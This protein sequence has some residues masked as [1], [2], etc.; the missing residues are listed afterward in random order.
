MPPQGPVPEY[1]VQDEGKPVAAVARELGLV[2]SAVSTW[3][4]HARADQTQK[5]TGLTTE[6]RAELGSLGKDNRE[7]R[8][9]RDTLKKLV[10][11]SVGR[12]TLA[13]IVEA[14]R[15]PHQDHAWLRR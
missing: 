4:Q 14:V 1:G 12:G 15:V 7:L 6:G 11:P 8:M 5:R 2:A 3:V 13:R 10:E 9:E